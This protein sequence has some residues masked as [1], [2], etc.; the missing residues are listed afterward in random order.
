METFTSQQVSAHLGQAIDK[1]MAHPILVTR[2]NRRAVVILNADE[3]DRLVTAAEG[4]SQQEDEG[5]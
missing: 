5:S 2:Y 1:A 4:P 3:Y